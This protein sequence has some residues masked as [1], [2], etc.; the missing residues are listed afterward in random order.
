M[1]IGIISPYPPLKGGISKETEII[2]SILK[3]I[4]SIRI[5]SFKNLYPNLLYPDK[6]QYDD[7]CTKDDFTYVDFCINSFNPIT[8][9]SCANKIIEFNCTHIIMRFW[10]PFFIPLYLYLIKKIRKNNNDIKIYCIS[11]NI[12][13]HERFIFDRYIIMYFLKKFNGHMVM[14]SQSKNLLKKIIGNEKLIIKS[15]LP[16]KNIYKNEVSKEEALKKIQVT[17]PK[18]LLL[19][20][21]LIRD[22]KGLDIVIKSLNLIKEYDVKLLIAGKCY[23]N[24]KMYINMIKEYNLEDK[25]IWHDEYIPESKVNY[26]FS[27]ADAVILSHKRIY[28]SGIIPLAYNFNKLI[29]ASDIDSFKE[30]IID[31]KTG[32]LF[33]KNDSFSLSKIISYIY[34]DHDFS[35]S[36]IYIQKYKKKY[37]EHEILNDFS[38]LLK[39]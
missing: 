20:F 23:Q 15:F 35:K 19:F 39:L 14:S 10:N 16:L 22:Y 21:G 18:L 32:Y 3:N 31:T 34:K 7:S 8:W 25:I 24:K 6:S 26:Y 13:P 30:H 12:I 28:Q 5:F 11:D 38:S 4:Y 36:E 29:I 9:R 37:S 2:Y 27:A 33:K 1:K 17:K